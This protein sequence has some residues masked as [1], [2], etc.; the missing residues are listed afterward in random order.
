M[1]KLTPR[2]AEIVDLARQKGRVDVEHL[3]GRFDVSPQTIRKDLNE[4]CDIGVLQRY[5]GGAMFASGV[6][7]V[8]YE[9][10]RNLA[11]DAK[12]AIGRHAAKIMPD[13]CSLFITIGT[14][15]EQVAHALRHRQGLMIIT[16]NLNV[17]HTLRGHPNID[18]VV[19]GGML[20]HSDGGIVGE[21]TVEFL[22][23]F[24]VDFAVM[25]V[26]AIDSDGSLLDFDYREVSVS[27]AIMAASRQII[28]V[29][30]TSKFSRSAPVRIGHISNIN[31]LVTD[32]PL[33]APLQSICAE[34]EVEVSVIDP[35][36][37]ADNE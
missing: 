3:T 20:R 25:G 1:Q 33:P 24:K 6:A 21:A 15:T 29:T 17:A 19:A 9:N 4:L 16:N 23:Q 32:Q 31:Y 36:A 27:K 12:Q 2:Q 5:H 10:R 28:L 8:G 34:H 30:D 26:S 35:D 11:A 37:E 13:N 18:I 14:T 7:N 22:R